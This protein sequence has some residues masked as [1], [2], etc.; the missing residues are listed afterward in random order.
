VLDLGVHFDEAQGEEWH[1]SGKA[2]VHAELLLGP[3][4]WNIRR[5]RV[6]TREGKPLR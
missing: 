5:A 3:D 2:T 6:D 4:G 1:S